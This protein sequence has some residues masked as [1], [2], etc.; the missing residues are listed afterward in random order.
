MRCQEL[1]NTAKWD[2]YKQYLTEESTV[3]KDEPDVRHKLCSA[4][5]AQTL[6]G[7]Q[8]LFYSGK[9]HWSLYSQTVISTYL[10][11]LERER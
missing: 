11:Y 10:R 5:V 1:K 4:L 8:T 2:L 3:S 6:L 7:L 9:V